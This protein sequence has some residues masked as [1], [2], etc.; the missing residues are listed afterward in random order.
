MS[1]LIKLYLN[2]SLFWKMFSFQS[3]SYKISQATIA[4]VNNGAAGKTPILIFKVGKNVH[5]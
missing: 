5:E 2:V 3:E 4:G 1:F